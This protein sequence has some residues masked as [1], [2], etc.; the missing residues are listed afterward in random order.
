M[1]LANLSMPP[2]PDQDTTVN[3][4]SLRDKKTGG[5]KSSRF[6]Y[7]LRLSVFQFLVLRK[8]FRMVV[9]AGVEMS[10]LFLFRAIIFHGIFGDVQVFAR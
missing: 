1:K 7:G 4:K 5:R 9:V 2:I 6:F 8:L 10:I 3:K